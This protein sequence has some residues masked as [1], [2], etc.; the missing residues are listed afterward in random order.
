[1]P[2][3]AFEGVDSVQSRQIRRRQRGTGY[4]SIGR[5]RSLREVVGGALRQPV[6]VHAWLPQAET[7]VE[8]NCRCKQRRVPKFDI[9]IVELLPHIGE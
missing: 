5:T 8:D 4:L 6:V 7:R 9:I 2:F 1:M 3:A